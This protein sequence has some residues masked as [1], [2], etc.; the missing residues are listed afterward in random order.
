MEAAGVEPATLGYESQER[1]PCYVL[2]VYLNLEQSWTARRLTCSE[3]AAAL[4]R[5]AQRFG[6]IS[7]Q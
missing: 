4:N 1:R 7:E 5:R 2:L 6:A 3:A